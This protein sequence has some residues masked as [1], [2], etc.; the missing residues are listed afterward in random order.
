MPFDIISSSRSVD[1]GSITITYSGD[2]PTQEQVDQHTLPTYGIRGPFAEVEA[3]IIRVE[4]ESF[5]EVVDATA[6]L[7]GH[8]LAASGTF[9]GSFAADNVEAIDSINIKGGA[10]G[11][12]IYAQP[13]FVYK[14][15][16][17]SSVKVFTGWRFTLPA[18]TASVVLFR[19][20]FDRVRS[21]KAYPSPP[22]QF[23]AFCRLYRNG[24]VISEKRLIVRTDDGGWTITNLSIREGD[25]ITMMDIGHVPGEPADYWLEVF[26]DGDGGYIKPMAVDSDNSRYALMTVFFK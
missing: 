11:A 10:V 13:S 6:I 25:I 18:F 19:F 24:T 5:F 21:I 17:S 1:D 22:L 2:A 26:K 23:N 3:G 15:N 4:P 14:S 20:M 12:Y 9:S 16:G 8:L 7:R